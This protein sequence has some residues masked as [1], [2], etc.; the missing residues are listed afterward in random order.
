MTTLYR[1]TVRANERGAAMA[2]VDGY[3]HVVWP[4]FFFFFYYLIR[5]AGSCSSVPYLVVCVFIL[6]LV[7]LM[8]Y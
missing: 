6:T 8:D 4:Y 7:A 1:R 2:L 3:W 5:S